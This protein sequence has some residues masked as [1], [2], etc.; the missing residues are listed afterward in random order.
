MITQHDWIIEN[1]LPYLETLQNHCH[2]RTPSL[3]VYYTFC[4]CLEWSVH[5]LLV[6]KTDNNIQTLISFNKLTSSKV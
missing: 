4:V 3:Q 6:P 5:K 1:T 2:Y